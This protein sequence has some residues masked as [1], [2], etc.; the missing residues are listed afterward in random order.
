MGIKANATNVGRLKIPAAMI[1][2]RT[3]GLRVP[4]SP[5][6]FSSFI[7]VFMLPSSSFELWLCVWSSWDTLLFSL[8]CFPLSLCTLIAFSVSQIV[9]PGTA[10]RRKKANKT[11]SMEFENVRVK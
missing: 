11:L 5:W 2:P 6:S 4:F 8:N 3:T 7:Y 9:L 10:R 1:I